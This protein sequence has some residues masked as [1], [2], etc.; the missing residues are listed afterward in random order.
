MDFR[1]FA[2]YL[3]SP[4]INDIYKKD[5]FAD[6]HQKMADL[7]G[8][9]RNPQAEGGPNAKQLNLARIFGMGEGR[10][11]K[12][13]GMDY[14]EK[15]WEE[16]KKV[17]LAPGPEAKAIMEQ[18]YESV[19]G[20]KNLQNKCSSVAKSRGYIKS[21]IGRR[22]RFPKKG[23]SYKAAG[24]LFQGTA[25]DAM[26]VKTIEIANFLRGTEGRLM[27]L[28]HDE[29]N[30]S[31]PINNEKLNEGIREILSAFGP[32]DRIHFNVPIVSEES[33]GVNWWEACK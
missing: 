28:V 19:P 32:G 23:D 15:W 26:K 21:I 20:I 2:H 6:F 24:L 17:Y 22:I 9:P 1:V 11:A 13:M 12:E 31:F 29:F 4:K 25:A 33:Q 30:C 16:K 18:Y 3:K 5:P 14:I 8:I 10:L 7:V 27:L